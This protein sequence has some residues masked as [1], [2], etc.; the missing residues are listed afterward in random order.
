MKRRAVDRNER[1]GR[2]SWI[3]ESDQIL[4]LG[5]SVKCLSEKRKKKTRSFGVID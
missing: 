5:G 2:R 4:D 1:R 3:G